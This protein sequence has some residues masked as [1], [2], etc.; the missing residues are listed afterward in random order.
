MFLF[1]FCKLLVKY[2]PELNLKNYSGY[3]TMC[4]DNSA[5]FKRRKK[6]KQKNPK[7]LKPDPK[8]VSH[9]H[10]QNHITDIS[11]KISINE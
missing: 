2:N 3:L 8:F 4:S 10:D 9:K 7:N 11:G 5:L 1:T 6:N